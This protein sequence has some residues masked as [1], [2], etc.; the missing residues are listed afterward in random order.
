LTRAREERWRGGTEGA[1]E[2]FSPD[3]TGKE[4][5]RRKATKNKPNTRKPAQK[6]ALKKERKTVSLHTHTHTQKILNTSKNLLSAGRED[7]V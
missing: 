6:T 5:R 1:T 7:A 3:D 4:R 2:V